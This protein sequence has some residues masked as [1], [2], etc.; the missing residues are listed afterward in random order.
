MNVSKDWA[1]S[2]ATGRR[3]TEKLSDDR[4]A[5]APPHGVPPLQGRPELSSSRGGW[6]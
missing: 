3:I 2:G 6:T 4:E 5:A 1:G